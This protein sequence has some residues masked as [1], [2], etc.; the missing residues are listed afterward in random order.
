MELCRDG[1]SG[2]EVLKD[3]MD[4]MD[5]KLDLEKWAFDK[6]WEL[7]S[8]FKAFLT[9]EYCC[10][11]YYWEF[12][13]YSYWFTP[14]MNTETIPTEYSRCSLNSACFHA[15]SHPVLCNSV[16]CGSSAHGIFFRQEHQSRL[17][18]PPPGFSR[19]RGLTGIS[20]IGRG[21]LYYWAMQ[22]AC[23]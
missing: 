16:D 13:V 20:C 14:E 23:H 22:E 21:V 7:N 17:P 3:F 18:F 4:K 8:I 6:S 11:L 1:R 9:V 19:P 2:L 10:I 12:F 5:L 15:Q